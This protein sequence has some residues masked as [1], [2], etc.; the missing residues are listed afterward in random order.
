MSCEPTVLHALFRPRLLV[1]AARLGVDEYNRNK[2]LRR[3]LKVSDAPGHARALSALILLESEIEAARQA[4]HGAY[5]YARHVEI[6]IAILAEAR[7]LRLS[8]EGCG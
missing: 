2:F 7:L 8:T 3:I 4:R 6:L 1:R 5:S